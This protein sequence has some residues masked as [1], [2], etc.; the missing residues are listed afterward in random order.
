VRRPL[1]RAAVAERRRFGRGDAAQPSNEERK[2]L[3]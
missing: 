1:C 2:S 3:I